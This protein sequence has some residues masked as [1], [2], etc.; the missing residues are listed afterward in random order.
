[1]RDPELP[2]EELFDLDRQLKE[3]EFYRS[4]MEES[5][6]EGSQ[7]AFIEVQERAYQGATISIGRESLRLEEDLKGVVRFRLKGDKITL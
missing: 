3:L 7:E 2:F 6:Y 1:M 5:L 4:L